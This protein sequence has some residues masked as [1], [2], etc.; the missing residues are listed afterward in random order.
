[1]KKD[2]P[3]A[4]EKR[5]AEFSPPTDRFSWLKL[6]WESGH[7]WE[8]AVDRWFIYQMIPAKAVDEAIIEQLEMPPP[9]EMGNYYDATLG[10]FV[11]NP[12]CMI[13]ERA[14]HLWR[15]TKCWGRPFWVIQGTKGGHKRW[16]S[17]LESKFLKLAG[18]PADPPIPGDLPYAP[19]DDRVMAQLEAY[20]LMRGVHG[21]LKR[22]KHLGNA[23][24]AIRQERQEKE[25][26]EELVRWLACQVE[27]I[28]PDVTKGLM[29]MDAPRRDLDVKKMHRMQEEAEQSFIET[30]RTNGQLL[31][32]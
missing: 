9:S 24:N 7:P 19:F 16:F 17:T 27:E 18:L 4:W 30:G 10:E 15:E 2:V 6:I 26:R 29:G 8:G 21:S 23:Q 13:T 20:D 1:M 25:F 28:A 31:T 32:L 11:R 5:L 14:W 3:L 12:D 22:N